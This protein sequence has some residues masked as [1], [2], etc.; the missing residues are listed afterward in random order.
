MSLY[1]L[2]GR[3]GGS[4]G[5]WRAGL[6]DLFGSISPRLW[7]HTASIRP[8][9]RYYELRYL[10]KASQS[11]GIHLVGS[12]YASGRAGGRLIRE[13]RLETRYYRLA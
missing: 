6:V 7:P 13:A 4:S 1:T 2:G 3:F 12:I 9:F 8:G 11:P 10:E 5:R